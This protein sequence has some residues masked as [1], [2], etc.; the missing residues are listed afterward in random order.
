MPVLLPLVALA[1]A[2]LLT[3]PSKGVDAAIEAALDGDNPGD[4]KMGEYVDPLFVDEEV[5][6]SPSVD[7]DDTVVYT[8]L[9]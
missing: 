9:E 7:D 3:M 8:D 4:A 2:L 5:T 6:G 1:C